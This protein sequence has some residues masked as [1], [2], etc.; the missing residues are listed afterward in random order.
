MAGAWWQRQRS[1]VPGMGRHVAL[2]QEHRALGC[3]VAVLYSVFSVIFTP[4]PHWWPGWWWGIWRDHGVAFQQTVPAYSGAPVNFWSCLYFSIVNFTTLGFSDIVAA[5]WQ[6]RFWVTVEVILGYV[7]L[8]GL[9]SIFANKF[10]R[11]S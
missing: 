5:N 2:R 11:R 6:A 1:S 8:G 4:S 10:A 7:M 9:I 3:M